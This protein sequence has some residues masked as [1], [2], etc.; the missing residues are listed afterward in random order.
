MIYVANEKNVIEK[1]ITNEWCKEK[2]YIKYYQKK[3]NIPD[4]NI[5]I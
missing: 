5:N 1:I 4:I 3:Y 2:D